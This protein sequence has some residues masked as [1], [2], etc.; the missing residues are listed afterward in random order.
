MAVRPRHSADPFGSPD[1]LQQWTATIPGV[2]T[3]HWLDGGH[4]LKGKDGAVASIV[5]D[6]LRTL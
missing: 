4:D 3:H 6:W 2:V 5:T 1:E